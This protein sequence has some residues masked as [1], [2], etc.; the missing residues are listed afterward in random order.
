[1][2]IKMTPDQ[3]IEMM[4]ILKSERSVWETHWQDL[5]DFMLPRKNEITRT[6]EVKGRKKGIELFDNTGLN[7]AE[8]LAGALHGLLTNPQQQWFELTTGNDALDS[9]DDV[10]I[11]LQG[12]A[13]RMHNILNNSN[14]QTEVHELYLDQVVLGTAF[15][16]ME[17]DE[18]TTVRFH[19]NHISEMFAVEGNKGF[20]DEVYRKFKWTA[21]KIVQEFAPNLAEESEEELTEAVGKSVARAFKKNK[22]DKFVVFHA[23]YRSD[24]REKAKQPYMSQYIVEMDKHELRE[25]GFKTF[26]YLVPRWT[27]A[28]GETYGRSPGMNAL[29][30][31]KTLNSMS[32]AVLKG[33]QKTVDPP[34]QAP[35]DGFIKPSRTV[36]GAILY[37][38]AGTNDRITPVFNDMRLDIGVEVTRDRQ[39]RIR[40]SFF[41]DQLQLREGPQMTATEV[42]R[43]TEE[44]MRLLGPMLGRQQSEFLAPLIERLF[45]IMVKKDM[46][47]EPPELIAGANITPK[48]SSTI[49]RAQRVDE[50]NNT[51]RAFQAS[52]PFLEQRPEAMDIID[53]EKVVRENWKNYGASQTVI[54][55]RE[56]IEAIR[57]SRAQAQ[58]EA[59]ERQQGLDNAD[60]VQKVGPA[61]Q[62]AQQTGQ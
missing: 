39:F 48:Y 59:K 1:M 27:K 42:N 45:D 46:I 3:I 4:Q 2:A 15:M 35:D 58:Q 18:I 22:N 9:N 23:V 28:T 36:P 38:R 57:E 41:V 47:G 34:I 30:E 44:R 33:A 43:R 17:E 6:D 37:Y 8:L 19:A 14:F 25:G 11:Y 7:S 40:E 16:H 12:L 29:P 20:I 50:G 32:L 56:E 31:A 54:R 10:R 52:A 24:F 60:A 62:Q 26:P 13:K 5:T 49:A 55:R 51:L 21:R 61:I 53:V